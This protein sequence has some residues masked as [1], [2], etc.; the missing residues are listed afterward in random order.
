MV[1][2][3]GMGPSP[4]RAPQRTPAPCSGVSGP[5]AEQGAGQP[6]WDGFGKVAS[7]KQ[8]CPSPFLW[9]HPQRLVPASPRALSPH[10]AQ[11]E[12]PSLPETH[13]SHAAVTAQA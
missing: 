6:V 11:E 9:L 12:N 3:R 10:T 2:R 1:Q 13:R 7:E 5:R 4:S 8:P